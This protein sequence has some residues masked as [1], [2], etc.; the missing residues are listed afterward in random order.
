[1]VNVASFPLGAV[2]GELTGPGINV[3]PVLLALI[4][5]NV[6]RV[7]TPFVNIP[8]TVPAGFSSDIFANLSVPFIIG[9]GPVGPVGPIGPPEGPVGPVGPTGEV[10]ATGATGATGIFD[11]SNISSDVCNS[12]ELLGDGIF[13]E[14]IGIVDSLNNVLQPTN[15]IPDRNIQNIL[16]WDDVDNENNAGSSE[17]IWP[18]GSTNNTFN[19]NGNFIEID[20]LSDVATNP[21]S[22]A[23]VVT[24][25]GSVRNYLTMTIVSND[26]IN[27]IND[28][29]NKIT[30]RIILSDNSVTTTGLFNPQFNILDLDIVGTVNNE[31]A[32]VTGF[33]NNVAVLPTIASATNGSHIINGNR[34]QGN[35]SF[36]PAQ[37]DDGAVNVQFTG[38]IDTIDIEIFLNMAQQTMSPQ[39]SV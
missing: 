27:D 14:R 7:H 17:N 34:I 8:P 19:I 35:S 3:I 32:I 30:I 15:I 1:M 36:A 23:P 5:F 9:S 31:V 12:I 28:N 10:G 18:D 21:F 26:Y 25:N 38:L 33:N 13:S 2:F 22:Q 6:L 4:V 20:I 16:S 37:L 29:G 39:V 11:V 24:T